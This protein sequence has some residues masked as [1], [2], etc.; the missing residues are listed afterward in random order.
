MNI[1]MDFGSTYSI[2]SRYREDQGVLEPLEDSGTATIPSVVSLKGKKVNIGTYAK[3]HTGSRGFRTFKA[4]KMLL[5]EENKKF[6]G[7]R[8]YDK[9]YSPK[10]ATHNFMENLVQKA[11]KTFNDN[12]IDHLVVGAPDVWFHKFDTLSGRAAVHEICTSIEGVQDVRIVSEPVLASAYFAWNYEKNCGSPFEGNILIVDYGGGTLDLSLTEIKTINGKAEIKMLESNGA[13]ENTDHSIGNAGIVYMETLMEYVIRKNTPS[14]AD[15]IL[16]TTEF[17]DAVNALENELIEAS[18]DIREVI[19]DVGIMHLLD[20]EEEE[21]GAEIDCGDNSYQVTMADLVVVYNKVIRPVF[22][23][24]MDEMIR[25]AQAEHKI[26]VL[27]KMSNKFRIALVGG[28]G[29]FYLVEQQMYEKFRLSD[30]VSDSFD[31]RRKGIITNTQD[32][33]RAISYG[34]SLIASGVFEI[35]N[36]APFSLGIISAVNGEKQVNYMVHYLKEINLDAPY[37]MRDSRGNA[38]YSR[39][40]KDW[41]EEFILD[42][43]RVRPEKIRFRA[44]KEFLAEVMKKIEGSTEGKLVTYSIGISFNSSDVLTLHVKKYVFDLDQGRFIAD[45]A[46]AFPLGE[47]KKVFEEIK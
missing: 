40:G 2:L 17:Y 15:D 36:T 27:N 41:S 22:E 47:Y 39:I 42:Y 14:E 7:D 37:Y 19:Q 1:G 35:C 32:C 6:V 43:G 18:E 3:N 34:A 24:K 20:L 46:A 12:S 9:K 26:D 33:E 28:F 13:G 21:M 44:K 31:H 11:Q 45:T 23:E 29:N 4:F 30:D 38:V 10:W 25:W 8:Q 16:Y 5:M